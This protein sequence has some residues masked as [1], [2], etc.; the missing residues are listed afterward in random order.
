MLASAEEIDTRPQN[1][2]EKIPFKDAEF[3]FV[4]P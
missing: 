3:D 1:D 2:P 4:T